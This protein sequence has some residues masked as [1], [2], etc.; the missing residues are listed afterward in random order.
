MIR[1]IKLDVIERTGSVECCFFSHLAVT[2]KAILWCSNCAKCGWG[3]LVSLSENGDGI[4]GNI[5]SQ[6]CRPVL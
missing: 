3:V 2:V 5:S 1:S 6:F 4:H